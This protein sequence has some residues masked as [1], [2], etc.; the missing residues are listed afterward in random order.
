VN[1]QSDFV[2]EICAEEK[3]LLETLSRGYVHRLTKDGTVRHIFGSY[4]DINSAASDRIACDKTACYTLLAKNEIPAIAHEILFNPLRR[5]GWA[6]E[7]GAW[8]LATRFFKRHG[9]KVVLKPNQGTQGQDI[10]LCKTIPELEAAAH[11]IFLNYPDAALSPYK[12][13]KN[14]YRAFFLNGECRFVYGKAKGNSWQHNLSQ[15]AVAFEITDEKKIAEIKSLATRAADCIGITFATI[16]I[17]ESPT[18]KIAVM[19]INSGVQCRRLLEQ[20]PHLRPI[21][22][23]IFAEAIKLLLART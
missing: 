17:A 21:I 1:N 18:G 10:Y 11:A 2:K 16:D 15:G 20:L 12:E 9:E 13:I 6:G 14:E 3:I 19:E 8:A 5:I 23:N 7:N 4:W 22:K